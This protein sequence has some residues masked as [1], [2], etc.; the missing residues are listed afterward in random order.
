MNIVKTLLLSVLLLGNIAFLKSSSALAKAASRELFE[1]KPELTPEQI[2]EYRRYFITLDGEEF[3]IRCTYDIENIIHPNELKSKLDEYS[4][5]IEDNIL[6]DEQTKNDFL[7][8]LSKSIQFRINE[9]DHLKLLQ[10]NFKDFDQNNIERKCAYFLLQE[11]QKNPSIDKKIV[12]YYINGI[13][14]FIN[15]NRHCLPRGHCASFASLFNFSMLTRDRQALKMLADPDFCSADEFITDAKTCIDKALQIVDAPQNPEETEYDNLAWFNGIR[16]LLAKWDGISP[17]TDA[18]KTQINRFINFIYFF[19]TR[20][21]DYFNLPVLVENQDG[22]FPLLE[23]KYEIDFE[24]KISKS[25]FTALLQDFIQPEKMIIFYASAPK[26]GFCMHVLGIYQSIFGKTFLYDSLSKEKKSYEYNPEDV[27]SI[28]DTIFNIF[29]EDKYLYG[30]QLK[31][32]T[33]PRL[34]L[35]ATDPLKQA[36]QRELEMGEFNLM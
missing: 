36:R 24:A 26:L 6:L 32:Y 12:H 5:L 10:N 17:L 22:I 23:N 34:P 9:Y 21:N 8:D 11:L 18:Q 35:D 25:D 28:V 14:N 4:K 1:E 20:Y 2:Q 30:L 33:F 29:Q 16:E 15:F 7:Q 27:K 13:T 31:T 3:D 19:F